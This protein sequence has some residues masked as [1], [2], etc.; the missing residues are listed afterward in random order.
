MEIAENE[1]HDYEDK[2]ERWHEDAGSYP[3]EHSL[4]HS[5]YNKHREQED[6]E[7]GFHVTCIVKEG[8]ES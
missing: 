4:A 8:L 1:G 3:S 5:D 6:R 7:D 2:D